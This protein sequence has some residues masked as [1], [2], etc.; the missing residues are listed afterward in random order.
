MID[1]EISLAAQKKIAEL[2]LDIDKLEKLS[3]RSLAD[4]NKWYALQ[5]QIWWC[6]KEIMSILGVE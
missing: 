2:Q 5:K 4:Y 1:K 6:R 3:S